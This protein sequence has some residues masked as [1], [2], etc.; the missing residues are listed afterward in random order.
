MFVPTSKGLD[1]TTNHM[2]H[3]HYHYTLAFFSVCTPPRTTRPPPQSEQPRPAAG[4]P[5]ENSSPPPLSC[6]RT[7]FCMLLPSRPPNSA[8]SQKKNL[9]TQIVVQNH[10]TYSPSK[11]LNALH[12]RNC[13]QYYFRNSVVPALIYLCFRSGLRFFTPHTEFFPTVPLLFDGSVY[14]P[15]GEGP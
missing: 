3:I 7:E 2:I 8:Y 14:H 9:I 10:Y 1:T 6:S 15:H 13:F 4:A 11:N 12:I 5:R